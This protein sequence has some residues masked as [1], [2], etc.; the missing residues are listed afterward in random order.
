MSMSDPTFN[1]AWLQCK[2]AQ[3]VADLLIATCAR[4]NRMV[5]HGYSEELATILDDLATEIRIV[6]MQ[7]GRRETSYRGVKGGIAWWIAL[8]P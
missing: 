2:N 4:T 8:T 1:Q 6:K 5:Y 7:D 3:D